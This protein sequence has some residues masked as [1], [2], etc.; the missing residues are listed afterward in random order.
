MQ[1]DQQAH[2]VAVASR[3]RLERGDLGRRLVPGTAVD[4][5]LD[6]I[7]AREANQI[8]PAR[9]GGDG[10]TLGQA[11]L[12][13]RFVPGVVERRREVEQEPG[14]LSRIVAHRGQRLPKPQ[15]R[16]GVLAPVQEPAG[17]LRQESRGETVLAAPQG[18]GA[19][20]LVRGPLFADTPGQRED[21]GAHQGRLDAFRGREIAPGGVGL[22]EERHGVFEPSLACGAGGPE[23]QCADGLGRGGIAMRPAPGGRA[24]GGFGCGIQARRELGQPQLEPPPLLGRGPRGAKEALQPRPR[25]GGPAARGLPLGLQRL[26]PRRRGPAA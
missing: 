6:A 8:L 17:F 16:A 19:D 12:A 25:L 24:A 20:G 15:D 26:Q 13:A 1:D 10:E 18:Q 22:L 9:R 2:V 3:Q 23:P 21:L 14:A 11:R 7:A 5:E 4:Q